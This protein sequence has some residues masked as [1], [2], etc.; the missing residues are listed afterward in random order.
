MPDLHVLPSSDDAAREAAEFV[1]EL[2]ERRTHTQD[3][4]KIALSGGSTPRSLYQLLAG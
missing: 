2:A 1:T 3:F 4:F